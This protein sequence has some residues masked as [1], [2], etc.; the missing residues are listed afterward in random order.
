M[1]LWGV[2][3]VRNEADVV[4]AFVR[5]N[6][7]FLD[8][9]AI[10]DHHSIDS[11]PQIL[12]RLK[13]EGLP[14]FRLQDSEAAFFQGSRITALARETFE[15]TGADYVFPLDADEFI[16]ADSREGLE[17]ALSGLPEGVYGRYPW[18]SYVPTAFDR[19]FGPHCLQWRL[20]EERIQRFKLILPRSFARRP[21]HMVSEGSHWVA[22]MR[23]GQPAG[24]HELAAAR[25][26]LAHCPVRSRAQLESKVR[27]GWEALRA[28]GGPGAEK[29]YH[30]RDIYDDLAAGVVLGEARLRLIASNYAVPREQWRDDLELAH[31][32]VALRDAKSGLKTQPGFA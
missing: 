27:L 15:R 25:L 21:E 22:D 13:L 7:A 14:V 9:L 17:A 12:G 16:R 23:S 20:R 3:M 10:L 18:R 5:H 4:E 6:L 30:W 26:C 19:P 11:T 24:H 1:K 28:A 2:S 31:D 29:A 32:P 8:G